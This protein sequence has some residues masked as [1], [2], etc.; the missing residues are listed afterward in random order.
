M[1]AHANADV[2]LQS[3]KTQ[4]VPLV[5]DLSGVIEQRHVETE[6]IRNRAEF[7]CHQQRLTISKSP[8]IPSK[9]RSLNREL[10]EPLSALP[11][12]SD[13]IRKYGTLWL[14]SSVVF[15]RPCSEMTQFSRRTGM[16]CTTSPSTRSKL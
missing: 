1:E 13:G 3:A 15:T 14:S 10:G 2:A 9:R 4:I 8:A 12:P 6:P 7:A 16:C 11:L 5:R